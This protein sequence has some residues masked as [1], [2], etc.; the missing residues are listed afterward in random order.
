[1]GPTAREQVS[2]SFGAVSGPRLEGAEEIDGP[3]EMTRGSIGAVRGG[4]RGGTKTDGA[5][6]TQ[7]KARGWR[8]GGGVGGG[9][10]G[11]G[12]GG[13]GEERWEGRTRKER[14]LRT[15]TEKRRGGCLY[16]TLSTL[17]PPPPLSSHFFLSTLLSTLPTP[18]KKCH[19]FCE[20]YSLS[21]SFV[22]PS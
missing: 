12:R 2:Y 16:L 5:Q 3:P 1:M 14:H 17:P 8:V 22:I 7:S 4:G 21:L 18:S 10:G 20:T 9:G 6:K 15:T 13:G 19:C 11:R